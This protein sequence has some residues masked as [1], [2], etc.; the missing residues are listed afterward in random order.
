M[1]F[2]REDRIVTSMGVVYQYHHPNS[3]RFRCECGRLHEWER[4]RG[5]GGGQFLVCNC[6]VEHYRSER[7]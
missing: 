1:R 2:W 6:G 7:A 3:R 4:E 5:E